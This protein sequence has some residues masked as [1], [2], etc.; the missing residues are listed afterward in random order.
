MRDAHLTTEMLDQLLEEDRTEEENRFLLHH[1]AVCPS[2]QAVGGYILVLY[3]AGSIDL[4]FSAVDLGIGKS[5][6]EAPGLWEDLRGRSAGEQH[7]LIRTERFRSW[8]LCELLCDESI[9][10]APRDSAAALHRAELAVAVAYE[11]REWEPAEPGWLALLRGH[12]LAHRANARRVA[13][14]LPD[15]AAAFREADQVWQPALDDLGDVLG[16]ESRYLALKASLRREERNF[17]QALDLLDRAQATTDDQEL[18]AKLLLG[19]AQVFERMDSLPEAIKALEGAAAVLSGTGASRLTLCI[20]HNL[21]WFLM[22][23]GRFLEARMRLPK[24]EALSKALG[25][26]LDRVRLDW[27]AAGIA[28]GLGDV[29]RADQLL[30]SVRRRFEA[31]GIGLDAALASLELAVLRVRTGRTDVVDLVAEMFSLFAANGVEQDAL[32]ALL[33][34]REALENDRLTVELAEQVLSRVREITANP[35]ERTESGTAIP[36]HRKNLGRRR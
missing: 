33:V 13:G 15:A 14:N 20:E 7:Q 4:A 5:R 19:K 3:E 18:K 21:L 26:E 8:G 36:V 24:V 28:A 25:N 2:C 12:A 10:E 22:S 32:A 27:V 35:T 23:T 6:L 29:A 16:Y 9:A 31:E 17:D 1:V 30:E 11:I 34:F